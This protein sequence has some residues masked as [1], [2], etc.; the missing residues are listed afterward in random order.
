MRVIDQS[1]VATT[2]STDL[3]AT[4]G[5]PRVLPFRAL[6]TVLLIT[7]ISRGEVVMTEAARVLRGLTPQQRA[8]LHLH[9]TRTYDYS[10]I[11]S[12]VADIASG[13]EPVVD[14]AT[15]EFLREARLTMSV[16][17]IANLIVAASIPAA[18]AR[19]GQ[20]AIDATDHEAWAARRS[21]STL[22]STSAGDGTK[23]RRPSVTRAQW[24]RAG[25]DGRPQHSL[26]PDARDGYR[27][28]K[29]MERKNIFLGYHLHIAVEVPT[30]GG[31]PVTPLS[32][33]IDVVPAGD[34][35]TA[36]GLRIIAALEAQ[37]T[38]VRHVL[39]DRGYT[40]GTAA[41]W[42]LPLIE[43]GI[44]QTLDLHTNQQVTRPGPI[45]GTIMVDG[46]LYTSGLPQSLR[47]LTRPNQGASS[48][49]KASSAEIFDKRLPYQFAA[50]GPAHPDG[51]RRYRGPALTGRL[52]CVNVPASMRGAHT[53]PLSTCEPGEPCAC[54]K[55]VT[56]SAEHSRERQEHAYG[57][58]RW[59][60]DYGRRSAVESNNAALKTH[61]SRLRHG[62][63][64]VMGLIKNTLLVGLL[65][66]ACNLN[67]IARHYLDPEDA[68]S[69][70][71]APWTR[72]TKRPAL[73]R[74]L[75]SSRG[76]PTRST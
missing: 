45:P 60:A 57:T 52:R 17:E 20:V 46:G 7:A 76:S 28:G 11:E 27:S 34:S 35:S 61:H 8:L 75:W 58:T 42:A 70:G 36:A 73:H 65:V 51:R 3:T 40:Y 29:N 9:P 44:T 30:L 66:A 31:P 15:G 4:T 71:A 67:V 26:D 6:F 62:C 50:F 41:A 59:L 56:L 19:T 69:D 25:A 32:H 39:A 22:H 72:P 47:K 16:S 18:V 54:G 10:H 14:L 24:P 33:A 38:P 48:A 23:R 21:R 53:I 49:K 55:T 43:R 1:G 13:C 5:R 63:I 64:R 37:G 12:G 68:P 2:V 74:R